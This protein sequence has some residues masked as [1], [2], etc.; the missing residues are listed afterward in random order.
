MKNQ[1]KLFRKVNEVI[2]FDEAMIETAKE[3]FKDYVEKGIILTEKFEED[4]WATTDEYSNVSF[5]FNL[6]KFR[7]KRFY[8][9]AFLLSYDEFI[10]YLKSFIVLSMEHHVLISLQIFLRDIKRLI[11][12]VSWEID[13]N[14][15]HIKIN[16]P[17]T[18]IDFL[19]TLPCLENKELSQL[20]EQLDELLIIN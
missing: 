1:S 11:K 3:C 9:P 15:E 12:E 14:M 18:C 10:D 6:N 7:Y 20:I 19:S 2:L 17:A 4:K 13:F 16:K 5:V 8:E